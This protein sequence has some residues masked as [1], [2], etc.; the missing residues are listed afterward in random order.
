MKKIL[1]LTALTLSVCLLLVGCGVQAE[2]D[3]TSVTTTTTTANASPY[4]SEEQAIAIAE[5]HFGIK[6]GTVDETTG[7]KM[8]YMVTQQPTEDHPLYVVALRWLVTVDGAPS[9]WSTL[10]TVEIEAVHGGIRIL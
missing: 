5:Q 7:Y 4:I 6:S 8:A 3:D 10:D 2:A 1:T 9:N